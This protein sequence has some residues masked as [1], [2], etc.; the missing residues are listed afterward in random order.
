MATKKV[1]VILGSEHLRAI[2]IIQERIGTPT[3]AAAIR[4]A[5]LEQALII[6]RE[7]AEA[8]A[9]QVR[10]PPAYEVHD[11]LLSGQGQET[12]RSENTA[13]SPHQTTL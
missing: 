13:R 8:R 3:Y 5:L 10:L 6:Q 1:P 9:L 11:V 2:D 7:L 4:Y 12:D